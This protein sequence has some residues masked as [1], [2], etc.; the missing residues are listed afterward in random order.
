[1]NEEEQLRLNTNS[2]ALQ[3]NR[4]AVFRE[5]EHLSAFSPHDVSFLLSLLFLSLF[6]SIYGCS[7]SLAMGKLP[8]NNC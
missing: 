7:V 5:A 8:M 1:M 2:S 3:A 6:V 4:D